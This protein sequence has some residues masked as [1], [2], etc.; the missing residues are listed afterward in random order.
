MNPIAARARA[1]VAQGDDDRELVGEL[2]V[3]AYRRRFQSTREP[4]ALGSLTRKPHGAALHP[5]PRP[6]LTPVC[7]G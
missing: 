1:E 7:V 3:P 2:T 5:G 6:V 4:L